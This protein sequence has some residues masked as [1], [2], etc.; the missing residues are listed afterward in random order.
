MEDIDNLRGSAA[1]MAMACPGSVREPEIEIDR[2]HEAGPVGTAAHAVF[3]SIVEL[4]GYPDIAAYAKKYGVNEPE[5]GQMA[6]FARI[7]WDQLRAEFPAAETEVALATQLTDRVTLTGHLDLL[8]RMPKQRRAALADLKSGRLDKDY[9]AQVF[10]YCV[11]VFDND[12]DIDEIDAS[13]IWLRDSQIE[14][15]RMNRSEAEAWKQTLIKRVVQ[16]DGVYHPGDHCAHC[17][18]SHECAALVAM[19]RR[20]LEVFGD[21]AMADRFDLGA[22]GLD[23]LPDATLVALKRKTKSLVAL[24]DSFDSVLRAT[25]K[26]RGEVDGGDGW[27][28]RFVDIDQREIDALAAWPALQSRLSDEEIAAGVSLSIGRLEDV[29]AKK[30]GKGKGAAAKRDLAADLEKA[31]AVS[32]RLV[33]QLRLI[34]K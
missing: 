25:V 7:A 16:W 9:S 10:S 8:S 11:L 12:P 17:K 18:R 22:D 19:A 14:R 6:K 30:A 34:R 4:G 3:D 15:Y 26:R 21:P 23:D 20:D 33:S 29:I 24:L 1:P 13:I 27:V 2:E 32:T 31:G 28:L 5:L